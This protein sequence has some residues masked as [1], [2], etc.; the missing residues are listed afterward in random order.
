MS[1]LRAIYVRG[2]AL[3]IVSTLAGVGSG[4]AGTALVA[5]MNEGLASADGTG[6]GL[7]F[8]G[9]CLLA[10]ACKLI[11]EVA[12]LR[13]TQRCI[14]ELRIELSQKLLHNSLE[15]LHRLGPHRLL[16]MLTDDVAVFANTAETL[17]ALLINGVLVI[18]CF[19]YLAYL[20]WAMFGM[21]IGLLGATIAAFLLAEKRALEALERLRKLKD[22]LFLRYR[23]LV[24]GTKELQQNAA[25]G[26]WFV[27]GLLAED[28]RASE[29]LFVTGMT[30][31]TVV[32]SVG[33]TGFYV[34]I[35]MLLF[36]S[37]GGL[38]PSQALLA[39][40]CVT[41]LYLM[42]P[43]VDLVMTVP[44][45]RQA[46]IALE[47]LRELDTRLGPLV[48]ASA[49]REEFAG[50]SPLRLQLRA[51]SHRHAHEAGERAFELGPI[52]LDVK[53]GEIV[54]I[55]GGNG[56]G[57]TTLAMLLLGLYEP[58]GGSVLLNGRVV[59]AGNRHAYRQ[60][61]S[62]V[63]SDFHLFDELMVEDQ[64]GLA[65]RAER[66]LTALQLQ[67]KVSLQGTRWSTQSLSTG[68]RKRLALL[69]AYLED[70]PVFVFDE[71]AADQD[72]AFRRIFYTQLL[73]ELR[74]RGKAV[75][76][77]THDDAYFSLADRVIK[78]EE[79]RLRSED[80]RERGSASVARAEAWRGDNRFE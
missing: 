75:I 34:I 33:M 32:A 39:S 6:L 5:L 49:A 23:S 37:P 54:F 31:Y 38:S 16:A 30:H 67:D 17:P 26:E 24:E 12:L 46:A 68:Q 79:G 25:R 3:A 22:R 20:S 52:D 65:E 51:L 8:F 71:W 48:A 9:C 73:P 78:L 77:I 56:S 18:G 57:K 64:A 13:L 10:L 66:Y 40:F 58:H 29:R 21:L 7:R 63:F 47:R 19:G 53:A 74:A 45:L 27:N 36:A 72:P 14:R 4:F 59:T 55:V 2:P 69:S 62:A 43:I 44:S 61:F 42:R 35:G 60:H 76:A 28:A 70:R 50:A 15:K 41:L 11:S 80:A 1:L